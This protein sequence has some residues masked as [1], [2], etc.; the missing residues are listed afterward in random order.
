MPLVRETGIRK[1]VVREEMA[2]TV[3]GF[4]INAQDQLAAT[5]G[6][7]LRPIAEKRLVSQGLLSPSVVEAPSGDGGAESAQVGGDGSL[8]PNYEQAA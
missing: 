7:D 2:H 1:N 5:K 4:A 8:G 3:G 6:P